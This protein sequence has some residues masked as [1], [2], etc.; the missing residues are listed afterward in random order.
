MRVLIM[1]DMEGVSGIVVWE[2]VNG[3]D[4]MYEEGRRL[5]TE[6]VN[7]AIRGAKAAGATEIVVMDCHG[8][9][10]A[11]TFNSFLPDRLERWAEYVQG[12]AWLRYTE[13]LERGCDAA[14]MVGFHAMA[15][16]PDGVLSHTISTEALHNAFIN[17]TLVGEAGLCAAV[18]G[19]WDVP[20]LLVTGDTATCREA[21]ELLGEGI[22]EAPVK[23]GLGRYA[24]RSLA[25]ADACDLIE[26]KAKEALSD[27]SRV[28]PYK[29]DEPATVRFELAT[30]EDAKRYL[31]HPAVVREGD[32]AVVSRAG[33]FKEAWDQIWN[34]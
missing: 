30:A 13:P 17:D 9:G 34:R 27:L 20:V 5:Y 28:K 18:C 22:V 12:H 16:T 23:V 15:G 26:A 24:A 2:Q 11:Y 14:L 3:G 4:P 19:I 32:R 25:P 29:P 7:A 33:T 21:R 1:S 6:E 10:G 31:S 8:A